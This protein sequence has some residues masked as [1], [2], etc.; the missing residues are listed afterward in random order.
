M[1]LQSAANENEAPEPQSPKVTRH[2]EYEHKTPQWSLEVESYH[3]QPSLLLFCW[4]SSLYIDFNMKYSMME[5][6]WE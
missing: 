2:K 1:Y 4:R 3:V 6:V 5:A